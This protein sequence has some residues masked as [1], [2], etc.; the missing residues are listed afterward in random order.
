MTTPLKILGLCG[1]L[2]QGSYNQAA[3]R[4]AQELAPAAGMTIESADISDLPLYNEDI[5]AQGFPPPVERLRKQIREAD[6][7]LFV[8]PEYNSSLPPLVKNS[9]DWVSRVTDGQDMV[10]ALKSGN[11]GAS[12][13]FVKAWNLLR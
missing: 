9:I 11:F 5:R 3:L 8:T 13:F 10:V 4:A 1:S 12:D 2:R 7:L 6:G